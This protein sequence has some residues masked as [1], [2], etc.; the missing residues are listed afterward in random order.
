MGKRFDWNDAIPCS[1]KE[2]T[3]LDLLYLPLKN[4]SSS[5]L[6]L[7]VQGGQKWDRRFGCSHL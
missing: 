3:K 5:K 6:F 2:L 7:A 4:R 1:N